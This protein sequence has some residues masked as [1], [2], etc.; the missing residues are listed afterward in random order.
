MKDKASFLKMCTQ[1]SKSLCYPDASAPDPGGWSL[2]TAWRGLFSVTR[3]ARVT[4]VT[5][6]RSNQLTTAFVAQL[7][8]PVSGHFSSGSISGQVQ[9]QAKAQD[10]AEAKERSNKQRWKRWKRWWQG[11]SSRSNIA[12][13]GSQEAERSLLPLATGSLQLG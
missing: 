2:V 3:V 9:V 12:I 5:P 13:A 7:R 1:Y 8:P 6:L 10:R 11:C 4:R